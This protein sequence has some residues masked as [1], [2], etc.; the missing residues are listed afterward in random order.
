L[1]FHFR[2]EEYWEPKEEGLDQLVVTREIPTIHIL[3]SREPLDQNE[4][5]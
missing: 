5:G 2:V 3:L 4:P 1:L